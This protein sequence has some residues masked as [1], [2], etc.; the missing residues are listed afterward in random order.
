MD[1]VTI[2]D[3]IG[4]EQTPIFIIV[5]EMEECLIVNEKNLNTIT[6][7]DS[8]MGSGKTSWSI[9]Y[10]NDNPYENFLYITPF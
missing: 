6:V 5:A 10:I 9:Q 2:C 7:I 8:L 1:G 4:R 3:S